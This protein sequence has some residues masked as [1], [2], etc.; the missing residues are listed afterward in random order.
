MATKQ[1]LSDAF[2]GINPTTS[3]ELPIRLIQLVVEQLKS[4]LLG[5]GFEK[6]IKFLAT[7]SDEQIQLDTKLS[8]LKLYSLLNDLYLEV[9]L[10]GESFIDISNGTLRHIK[11]LDVTEVKV[12]PTDPLKV[13]YLKEQREFY[14]ASENNYKVIEV[15]HYLGV[16]TPESE[17]DLDLLNLPDYKY[18]VKVGNSEP[19][20]MGDRL[21]IIR[22]V[23]SLSGKES[24]SPV[25]RLIHLQLE[26]NDIRSRIN[27]NGKHC[28]PQIYTIGTSAP[29]I[30]GRT[31]GNRPDAIDSP[32]GSAE[33][34]TAFT[35]DGASILHL[36][37][38]AA[39]AESGITPKIGYL[40]PVDSSYLERQR[41]II[42]QDIYSLCGVMVLELQNARSASS[43]SSLA[44]LYEPLQRATLN[45]AS[46]LIAAISTIFEQLGINITY[47]V[48]L[49]DVMPRNVEDKK[50]QI[51]AVKNKL[52][53][54]K[55]Y[56]IQVEGLSEEEAIK[57]LEQLDSEKGLNIQFSAALVDSKDAPN[58]DDGTLFSD[59]AIDSNEAKSNI[60]DTSASIDQSL[61][62]IDN[63][64]NTINK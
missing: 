9:P 14:I 11:A 27:L 62:N 64:D 17:S 49:P 54:R 8:E 33:F 61:N 39:A 23:D 25:E 34:Q 53:S 7:N 2:E 24:R 30:I 56:L 40:Q 47:R 48:E 20:E 59:K 58:A 12:D 42:L 26:Y 35:N 52:I 22:V 63:P 13:V 43:S 6:R 3:K 21:P 16:N 60:I 36:P 5:D 46:Y 19:I 1:E 29:A 38:S 57:E 28:K 10:Y 32:T 18:F 4:F 15:E 44:V 55:R 51:E 31:N 45:R 50:L 37:I 41:L